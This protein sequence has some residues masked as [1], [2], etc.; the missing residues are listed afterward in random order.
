MKLYIAI[1]DE[2]P[3]FMTPTLVGHAVLGAHLRFINNELYDYWLNNS[4]KKCVVRVNQKE[5]DKIKLLSDVYVG[6]ENNTLEGKDSC[7]V[8]CPREENPNV[9]KFA[10]LWKPK[11]LEDSA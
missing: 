10:K 7:I 8:V 4:F 3:D 1:L 11:I 2:F 5:F 9:L 6:H